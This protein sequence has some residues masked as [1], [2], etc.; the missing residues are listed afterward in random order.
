[1][2]KQR[3]QGALFCLKALGERRPDRVGIVARGGGIHGVER[4]L[5]GDARDVGE[6]AAEGEREAHFAVQG[7]AVGLQETRE[8]AAE[9]LQEREDHERRAD[10]DEDA[11]EDGEDAPDGVD[12]GASRH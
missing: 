6:D 5:A 3:R 7:A 11:E 12:V 4:E 1:M 9:E 8:A 2:H 10:D